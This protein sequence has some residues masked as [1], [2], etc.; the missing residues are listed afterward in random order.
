MVSMAEVNMAADIAD[1]RMDLRFAN[2]RL[3]AM[4]I[5]LGEANITIDDLRKQR[6]T[7]A[8]ALEWYANPKN[9][10]APPWQLPF[11]APIHKDDGFNARATLHM[12][13]WKTYDEDGEG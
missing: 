6:V 11:R 4:G 9:Y 7:M 12:V 8:I 1:L 10:C 13:H 3:K 5:Q 2:A